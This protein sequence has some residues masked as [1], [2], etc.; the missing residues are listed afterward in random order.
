M[1]RKTF[2]Y[3]I[4]TLFALVLSGSQAYCADLAK[5]PY[6]IV[7]G[8][9]M[10]ALW[11]ATDTPSRSEIAWGQSVAYGN[12]SGSLA[13]SGSGA[14][15][16]QFHYTI[17]GLE[18]AAVY[19][20]R[21]TV[22]S[23]EATGSFKAPP[24]PEATS[25]TIYGY[26]DTRSY[27]ADH[28]RVAGAILAD[29]N[30]APENRQT[31]LLHSG[32]WVGN[33]D[34]ESK[35]TDEYFNRSYGDSLEL[36]SRMAVMGCRGNHEEGAGLLRKYWPYDGLDADGFYYAFDYGPVH[37]TVLDQYVPF[38]PGSAQYEWLEADL[39]GTDKVWKIVLF[40]EP[41]WSAGGHENNEDTQQYL[42]P[43]FEKYK[44]AVA[45]TGHNHYYA[46]CDVN[47]VR[48]ITAGGG[49]APLRSP[50]PDYPFVVTSE[51]S[52]HFLRYEVSP[53]RTAVS[54]I[55]ENGSL[56]ERFEIDAKE[57]TCPTV[58]PEQQVG[59]VQANPLD[60]VSGVAASR[61]NPGVLWMHNDFP[62]AHPDD[63][64][65]IYATSTGG[66]ILAAYA[67]SV[68]PGAYDPEDIAVGPGPIDG[69]ENP[70]G[71]NYIYWGDIGDNASRR[72]EIWIKRIPEPDVDSGR[73]TVHETLDETD[74]VEIIRLRY[75]TGEDAPSHKDSETLLVDP[76]NGDIY[77]VTK[78][79][80]PNKVYR[81]PYPQS[82][83]EITTLSLVAVLPEQTGLSWITAGDISHDGRFV[84]LKNNGDTDYASF[85]YRREGASVGDVLRTTPCVYQLHNEPQGEA[86]GWDPAGA[87]FYTVSEAHHPTEPVYYYSLGRLASSE[88]VT[89]VPKGAVWKYLDDGSDQGT[90]WRETAFDDSDWAS[91][92]AQLGY[93]DG[94]ELTVV[95]YGPDSSDKYVTTYFRH[96]FSAGNTESVTDLRLSILRDDGAIVYLN[97]DEVF[98]THMPEGEVDGGAFASSP[99]V[100]GAE[101]TFFFE[102]AVDPVLLTEG[103]NVI[104]VE[105]HQAAPTSSDI[106]FDLELKAWY[107]RSSTVVASN[108]AGL[109]QAV[110]MANTGANSGL[111]DTILLKNGVYTL[112]DPLVV[113][114]GGITVQS[115]SGNRDDVVIR[116]Q[117]VNGSV[118]ACFT[119]TGADFTLENVTLGDVRLH[120]VLLS[121]DADNAYIRG[122]RFF[123]TGAQMIAVSDDPSNPG[124]S[125]DNGIVEDCTFEYTEAVGPGAS[126]GGID[127][128]KAVNWIV[129]R[130]TFSDIRSPAGPPG[131]YAVLFWADSEGALVESNLILNCDR[132]VGFGVGDRGHSGGI[133]RN[134]MI[135]HD[136]Y[137]GPQAAAGAGVV[138]ES[139]S[140]AAVYNNTIHQE[141]AAPDAV[142]CR[143][144]TS[145]EADIVNNLTNKAVSKRDGASADISSNIT[146]AKK[147]WF[148]APSAGNLRLSSPIP[149]V[150]DQGVIPG[151]L[152]DDFDGDVRPQDN[153]YDIGADEYPDRSLRI[154]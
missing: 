10:K 111:I 17:T 129:R 46:R 39:S 146:N 40:H 143:F 64:N 123:D 106:G 9:D 57:V 90:L 110:S 134:N 124:S 58:D 87:G 126:V 59:E 89:L 37:V 35:W 23:E 18:P 61:K 154:K 36:M 75:P 5:G 140:G 117:G 100:G 80:Y 96:S 68:G 135:Y 128:K 24:A 15:E 11:Q 42:C 125:A 85:W 67:V 99:A 120:A 74:G 133:I 102:T 130:N 97:G 28:D 105:V 94:D 72:S 114:A 20:Y 103:A 144:A 137:D 22:D 44:V 108:T 7:S 73:Q 56:I 2:F 122:V 29:L 132:G 45:H 98:R 139:A 8:A 53:D 12:T 101:E 153:G 77:V 69:V 112:Y 107:D 3:A 86:L 63:A 70:A 83:T 118:D 30:G 152:F 4:G 48:H 147:S 19:Y 131:A 149:E 142:V 84:M 92:P 49:G 119:V 148:V 82:T 71:G 91:G 151:E 38:A 145:V 88:G 14:N 136:S 66:E 33:G 141:H 127:A 51:S 115:E 52:R 13:E 6:L 95:S 104:E 76:E 47:G 34:L 25:V 16:H 113:S 50:D 81:A 43:L 31:I 54:V 55:R 116:G 26:G 65:R 27:P 1:Q 138:L 79:M 21:V 78:R 41:A 93:G 62:S 60:E 121:A 32:D 109:V 150:V